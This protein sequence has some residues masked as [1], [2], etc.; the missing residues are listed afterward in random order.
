[1]YLK[2]LVLKGFKSFADRSVLSM[3]PGITAIVGPNGSGKSNISDAVLWVL[4]ER[5]AKNLRGQVMEDV[6]FAGS[7]ARKSVGTAEVTLVLDNS[8][9]SLPVDYDEVAVTR[10]M[11]RNGE[12][13][14]L[15]NNTLARRMDVLDILHDSGL[16]TGTHSII[17]QG[18]L[19]N[20]L[21]SKPEDRR[22]L[23]E[24]AAGVLKHKQRKAK[25]QRKLEQMDLHLMR[26]KDVV[27]EVER[28][29]GPL[30]RKAR[31]A[32]QYAEASEQ[33]KDLQLVLAVDDLRALKNEWDQIVERENAAESA[34]ATSKKKVE[35][36]EAE[37]ERLQAKI[38]KESTEVASLASKQTRVASLVERLESTNLL[39][40]ERRKSAEARCVEL[41]SELDSNN[42][43]RKLL[44][45]Q[46][47]DAGKRLE[48]VRE[49]RTEADALLRRA[50]D[51]AEEAKQARIDIENEL[52]KNSR[53]RNE[54][55]RSID[56]KR[57]E[58]AQSQ[59]K[60]AGA[61]GRLQAAE[62]LDRDFQ[63]RVDAAQ[64]ALDEAKT[65][66]DQSQQRLAT[67]I[68]EEEKKRQALEEARAN[69]D[70]LTAD[71]DEAQAKVRSLE[72]SI[73]GLEEVERAASTAASPAR[74]WLLERKD[75]KAG[76]LFPLSEE[77][78]VEEGYESIVE[79]LLGSDS[80]SLI[81]EDP[82]RARAIDALLR[83]SE[84]KGSVTLVLAD[85]SQ[86]MGQRGTVP[87]ARN[88]KHGTPLIT[89]LSTSDAFAPIAE[90][91]LGDVV[92][93]D[94]LGAALDAHA[95]D[96]EGLRFV[97]PE[98][99]VVF[100]NGKIRIANEDK[101]DK[102]FGSFG[103]S[104][105]L[106]TLKD[107]LALATLTADEARRE[108]EK[109]AEVA[110]VATDAC[111][112]ASQKLADAK[113]AVSSAEREQVAASSRLEKVVSEHKASQRSQDE[114]H[115]LVE[116]LRPV[117]ES[118][119][120]QLS[121]LE[122]DLT[123]A[124]DAVRATQQK[125]DPARN[126]EA[127]LS[128]TLSETKLKSVTLAQQE[129]YEL[130]IVEERANELIRIGEADEGSLRILAQK[131]HARKRTEPLMATLHA[132]N[133]NAHRVLAAI[134]SCV[135]A[136][137]AASTGA[138]ARATEAR[139]A[140][141]ITQETLTSKTDAL[142][143]VREEKVRLEIRV[144][145]LADDIVTEMETTMEEALET[146]VLDDRAAIE[147]EAERLRRRISNMGTINPDAAKE[148]EEL[149]ARYDYLRAQLDDLAC[150]R[151]TLKKIDAVID[152]RM[153]DDFSRTFDLVNG[154][155]Q[156]IF[157]QLFPGGSATLSLVD[158]DDLEN[159]G[160]EVSAQPRGKKISK[161]SLMSGGEKSLV[162]LALLFAVYKTR[163]TPFYILDEVEA[164]LDDSNLRRL[165]SYLDALREE[166][167]LIMITHQRR[168][169]EMADVLFGV[170]MQADGVTRVISQRLEKALQYA[171]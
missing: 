60:L 130:H 83:D 79:R 32:L 51:E 92:L 44:Q 91:L 96:K 89:K 129:T 47:S 164:A 158:P 121:Q 150:A 127:R 145:S 160:V 41:T 126:K 112:E 73:L 68:A 101:T 122:S 57:R 18:H 116:T 169:M 119:N 131:Q 134:T 42:E 163:S 7:S 48:E 162:A 97:T 76:A 29:L 111:L 53:K 11:Y 31:R 38:R 154:H 77:L 30:Q 39:L 19:D 6:I 5:N 43:R 137:Q 69:R 85:E 107:D 128:Q 36:A 110:R 63:D 168:T 90:A 58:L 118:L 81:A 153:K 141:R 93:C 161:M 120:L 151:A 28:Q 106:V 9:G 167:Q 75:D 21:S 66:L 8:D 74:A 114:S 87:S 78:I 105:R 17:S 142:A 67:L 25:S 72:S 26:V 35:E 156:Q 70:K 146:P 99:S 108:A 55:Q 166:T 45:A 115:T 27:S 49:K 16:G 15:I 157:T 147:E 1:M 64:K 22:A 132:I 65:A 139:N 46:R 136:A 171:E 100:P 143:S 82:R 56:D 140:Y 148:Y 59:E 40:S 20:I 54:I 152:E 103:R 170:S 102:D 3:E 109:A 98:G 155:F 124:R 2:S 33:L 104:R 62:G 135:D 165:I 159:T 144:Q 95:Q 52:S 138:S 113:G 34:L 12:S 123:E 14:Y 37:Y 84:Q 117:V 94:T 125:L 86:R 13:D 50:T 133:D 61:L 88:S 24:E 149:K 80:L 10:R 71:A 4:G 23:I